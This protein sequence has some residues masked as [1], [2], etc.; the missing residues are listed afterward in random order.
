[1]T[2]AA[3]PETSK[4][5]LQGTSYFLIGSTSVTRKGALIGL[6]PGTVVVPVCDKGKTMR[7]R[8]EDVELDV[9]KSILTN[10]PA[11]AASAVAEDD[12]GQAAVN[13]WIAQQHGNTGQANSEEAARR[14]Q[15]WNDLMVRS[16]T[17]TNEPGDEALAESLRNS[18][19]AQA[20]RAGIADVQS[21]G[22]EMARTQ[23]NLQQLEEKQRESAKL[24]QARA[25][26]EA[27]ERAR[28][29]NRSQRQALAAEINR[30][31]HQRQFNHN[32]V[33]LMNEIGA[34][35]DLLNSIGGSP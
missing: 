3:S 11:L 28:M 34:K 30:L 27:R 35:R 26:S 19:E 14:R 10:D 17:N 12:R 29:E 8:W 15:Q 32:D 1:M 22:R 7:V 2:P 23:G 20:V 6:H 18:P 33:N 31:E 5:V 13:G 16:A 24:Q 9:E 25:D 4:N 21:H